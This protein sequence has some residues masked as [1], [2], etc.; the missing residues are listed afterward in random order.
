M[1]RYKLVIEYDGTP[2]VGW[3]I[4][5][6]HTSVQG[7]LVKAFRAFSNEEVKVFGAGRTDTGVHA[8]GQAIHV[9]ME[10]DWDPFKIMSALN[11]MLK[12][13]AIAALDCQKIADDFDVRFS[14][15]KRHYLYR[16]ITRRAPLVLEKNRAWQVYRPLDVGK[17]DE[18]AQQLIGEHDFTAF[19]SSHCQALSPIK[20]IDEIKVFEKDGIIESHISARSFMHHQVRSIMGC[21]KMVGDGEW[22]V[23]AIAQVLSSC[24]RTRCAPLAPS[25]GLY[26]RQVDYPTT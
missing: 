17:M 4:Q 14:A 8:I 21:L 7:Q 22:P 2:Y 5:K 16:T 24:D 26:L 13:D 11:H 23:S 10:K 3:Q 6:E 19:R 9:D 1:P 18:A 12:S 15:V 20:T 25:H